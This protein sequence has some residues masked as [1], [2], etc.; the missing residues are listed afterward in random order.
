MPRT[1]LTSKEIREKAIEF[2]QA[3]LRE[4]GFEKL[5]L[6]DVANDIDVSHVA[7]YRHF[8]DKSD[9]LEAVTERWLTDMDTA[10]E[11]VCVGNGTPL[12]RIKKWYELLYLYKMQTVKNDP[13][14]FKAYDWNSETKKPSV[15]RH[16]HNCDAQITDLLREAYESKLLKKGT[17]EKAKA[18][19]N[20]AMIGFYIPRML[21]MRLNEN[22][23]EMLKNTIETLIRGLK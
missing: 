16:L 21:V 8:K 2:A 3:R 10:L 22:R 5:R 1:G 7:L 20:E 14:L 23:S 11:A 12:Q 15:Q 13:E 9:L 17:P 19:L 4:F 18:I 6:T